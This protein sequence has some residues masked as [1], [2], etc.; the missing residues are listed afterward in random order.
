[1]RKIFSFSLG[2]GMLLAG[3]EQQPFKP[4]WGSD[5]AIIEWMEQTHHI[6]SRMARIIYENDPEFSRRA[7][8]FYAP[9]P[10]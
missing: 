7:Y 2:L 6:S 8:L 3:C 4:E 9:K 1:M 10:Q 5:Q